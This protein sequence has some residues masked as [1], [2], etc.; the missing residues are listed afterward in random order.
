MQINSRVSTIKDI[1]Y[2][3]FL[4]VN[5]IIVN[6]DGSAR[7]YRCFYAAHENLLMIE[8]RNFDNSRSHR[9][10]KG[11]FL[12]KGGFARCYELISEENKNIEAVKIIQKSSLSKP[13][14]KQKL[15]SEI[16]IHQSLKHHHVV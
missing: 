15:M 16:K 7:S 11:N 1:F 2:E 5:Y 8:D 14:S 13:R 6:N 4:I 12:G 3:L 10:I 9:Y